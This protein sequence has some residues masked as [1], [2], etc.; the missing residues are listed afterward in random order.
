MGYEIVLV[1]G[2]RDFSDRRLMAEWLVGR[3]PMPHLVIHD[4][5]RGADRMA[6]EIANENGIHA[7][8][9]KALWD[10][11]PRKGPDNAGSLRN[12]AMLRLKP[13]RVL[14]FPGGRGTANCITQA[15]RLG[16]PVEVVT[17][18]DQ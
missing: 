9:V 4:G 11:Y 18:D 13:D 7:A 15:E 1:C 5:A 6:G 10:F 14:A 17:E 8:E 2:G 16:I 3:P 12:A